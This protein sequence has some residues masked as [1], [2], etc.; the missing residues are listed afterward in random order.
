M[1]VQSGWLEP[2]CTYP[3]ACMKVLFKHEKVVIDTQTLNKVGSLYLITRI[4]T[5]K[6]SRWH[7]PLYFQ[8]Q[9]TWN[10]S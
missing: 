9:Q 4:Q 5:L 2:L 7:A 8:R 10:P 1:E 6:L 3:N